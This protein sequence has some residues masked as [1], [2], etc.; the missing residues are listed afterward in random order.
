MRY[1]VGDVLT[2]QGATAWNKRL[3]RPSGH[4]R[5]VIVTKAGNF[6]TRNGKL[7][8]DIYPELI[9]N[10]PYRTIVKM[11]KKIRLREWK[12]APSA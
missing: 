6:I 1:N 7:V 12:R 10:G 4:Y 3:S 8:I 11:P 2:F 5:D 9:D